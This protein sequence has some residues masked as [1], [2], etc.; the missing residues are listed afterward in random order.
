MFFLSFS[1]KDRNYNENIE[2]LYSIH[3]LFEGKIQGS[4][5]NSVQRHLDFNISVVLTTLL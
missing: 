5:E 1:T 3:T 2:Q 4:F